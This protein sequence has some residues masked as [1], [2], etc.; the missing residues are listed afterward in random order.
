[1]LTCFMEQLY[2]EALV[3]NEAGEERTYG[4]NY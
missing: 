2:R 3:R 4:G 1:M